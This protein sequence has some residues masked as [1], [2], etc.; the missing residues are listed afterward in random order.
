MVRYYTEFS[1]R[2]FP[3]YSEIS[4][5]FYWS[6]KLRTL[7]GDIYHILDDKWWYWIIIDDDNDKDDCDDDDYEGG[8]GERRRRWL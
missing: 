3:K 1:K 5:R 6:G 7:A 4:D 2:K 8:G